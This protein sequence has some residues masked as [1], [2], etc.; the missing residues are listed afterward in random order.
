MDG[1]VEGGT[2]V[3]V[4]G[5]VAL[6]NEGGAVAM[7]TA[8]VGFV[9]RRSIGAVALAAAARKLVFGDGVGGKAVTI[10][11]CVASTLLLPRSTNSSSWWTTG[12]SVFIVVLVLLSIAC[13][14][15]CCCCCCCCCCDCCCLLIAF[16][17]VRRQLDLST[18]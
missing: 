6:L 13:G 17:F 14:Y 11:G 16:D 18:R 7:E 8:A 15:F 12:N 9:S 10:V 2:E 1:G 5:M 3:G 4:D